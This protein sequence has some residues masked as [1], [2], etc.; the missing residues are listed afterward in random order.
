VV[1]PSLEGGELG[2]LRGRDLGPFQSPT[3]I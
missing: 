1:V 2:R 3:K